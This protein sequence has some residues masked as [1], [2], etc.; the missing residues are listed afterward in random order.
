MHT[1]RACPSPL[2][3]HDQT[4]HRVSYPLGVSW[5]SRRD[6]A[7]PAYRNVPHARGLVGACSHAV[8]WGHAP[9]LSCACIILQPAC[10]P[11]RAR[12]LV[13]ARAA[14]LS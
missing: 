3:T 11:W 9:P 14:G 12:G 5:N 2:L 6:S 13:G 4:A 7:A 1:C 8:G 10:A